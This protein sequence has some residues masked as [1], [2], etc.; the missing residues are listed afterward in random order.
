M[1]QKQLLSTKV[2]IPM[3]SPPLIPR[4]HLIKQLNEGLRHKLILLTAPAGYGKTTLLCQ[5]SQSLGSNAPPL[6][7]ISLDESDNDEAIFWQYVC[8]ALE[9]SK[10]PI[11]QETLATFYVE[12]LHDPQDALKSLLN[13]LAKTSPFILVLDNCQVI[14][15]PAIHN[16]FVFTLNHMPNHMHLVLASRYELSLPIRLRAHGY[17]LEL[18][19][20]DFYFTRCEIEIF[21]QAMAGFDLPTET[22]DA[23]EALTEGWAT[24]LQVFARTLQKQKAGEICL[25]FPSTSYDLSFAYL[26][27]EVLKYLPE[28]TQSFLLQTSILERFNS[29]LCEAVTG[30]SNSQE[31]LEYLEQRNLFLLPLD[32]VHRWYRYHT[33]FAQMLRARLRKAQQ[34]DLGR[35]RMEVLH[36]R[37][38]LWYRDHHFFS[39]AITYA[40]LDGKLDQVIQVAEQ[41]PAE[42]LTALEQIRSATEASDCKKQDLELLVLETFAHEAQGHTQQTRTALQ[43]IGST[44][45]IDDANSTSS[46]IIKAL[47]Q[48]RDVTS[49]EKDLLAVLRQQSKRHTQSSKGAQQISSS[50]DKLL[51]DRELEILRALATGTTNQEIADQLVIAPNTVKRH[52]RSI[53]TKLDVNNRT[54]A[55][56][57]AQEL[58]IL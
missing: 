49:Q 4:P 30:E 58:G 36:Q 57:Q 34:Q 10:I 40:L 22:L 51:S 7:W 13:D 2:C 55:V 18:Y 11:C 33:L 17:T 27:E 41:F 23:L 5:W 38:F 39:E 47:Q 44:N 50:L 12:T 35:I 1:Q 28:Q 15:N 43:K 3:M 24:G 32:K 37:A 16:M 8:F 14:T 45:L 6:A 29:S 48:L 26:G 31:I 19:I 46:T 21:C 9:S 56:V 42:A 20:E 25:P 54:K 52:V 53:L